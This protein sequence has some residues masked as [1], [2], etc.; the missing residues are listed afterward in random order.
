VPIKIVFLAGQLYLEL[1]I[2]QKLFKQTFIYGLA[3]VLPRMLSFLLVIV[4][5]KYLDGPISFGRVT[6]LF[7]WMVVFNVVLA[8]G[9]ET[10]FF[11]FLNIDKYKEKVTSTASISIVITTLLFVVASM[12][13]QNIV[14]S[15][16]NIDKEF[17]LYLVIILALDALV[18]IPFAS[19][20]AQERPIRYSVI[21]I[22]NVIINVT[23]N[24]FFLIFLPNLSEKVELLKT[25]YIEDFQVQYILIANVIAS[26]FTLLLMAPFYAKIKYE[27]NK[28][29]W[30]KMIGYGTPILISGVAFAI[31]ESFD[32]ILLERVLGG[33]KGLFDSGAYAACYKLA[34]FMTLFATAF[35]MG[36]EPFFFSHAKEKD[37]PTTYATITKY[38]VIFGSFILIFI[39]TFSDILKQFMIRK[40]EYWE[41]MA[42]VPIILLANFCLGIYHN[43][44]VWYKVTDKTKY[45]A[46]ISVVG[47][48]ITLVINLMLIP[49]YSYMGSA[50][51]TLAAY[52]SMM[53]LSWFLG[54]KYYPIPYNLK[55][56]GMYLM[57]SIGFS[58][59][60]FYVFKGNYMISIPLLL[61]FLVILYAAERK[62][63]KQI[64][65][66]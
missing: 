6:I 45:G 20:R 61:V 10:S 51:A 28:E 47:A 30:N 37:A 27:F 29:L 3:T 2:F 18:I 52:G 42:V 19:L 17:F 12:F 46:Y 23:F 60:S 11:R 58:V 1:G 48:I 25:I 39:V 31:N 35:R 8:Y 7:S 15:L 40:P 59:L 32:K 43:L 56:I 54:R 16:L 55:K 62:E 50:I 33:E 65:N 9:M 57:I 5:T 4:H 49:K 34:L 26:G 13:T 38:F 64:L 53:L 21:K 63:L 66:Q 36:I 41:A 24:I 14:A 44:S 22:S